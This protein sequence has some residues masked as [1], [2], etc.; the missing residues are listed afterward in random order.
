[1]K[2]SLILS[3]IFQELEEAEIEM[4]LLQKEKA[5]QEVSRSSQDG[6]LISPNIPCE[7]LGQPWISYICFDLHVLILLLLER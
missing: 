1:M 3:K 7:Y 6:T 2:L 5:S 4:D